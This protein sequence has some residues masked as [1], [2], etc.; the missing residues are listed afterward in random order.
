MSRLLSPPGQSRLRET[1]HK[2]PGP[3]ELSQRGTPDSVR[4][5]LN[6]PKVR[7]KRR[8]ISSVQLHEDGFK[9]LQNLQFLF[10]ATMSVPGHYTP[11][12]V[13]GSRGVSV[14]P[15]DDG[16]CEEH[17]QPAGEAHPAGGSHGG[18]RGTE[19]GP[20]PAGP[21]QQRYHQLSACP[22]PTRGVC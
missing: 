18:V 2:H 13:S 3:E 10:M 4:S 1:L 9:V 20:E 6:D 15:G 7:S 17:Q 5:V 8:L 14:G 11:E 16:G 12:P 22:G 21:A 19:A